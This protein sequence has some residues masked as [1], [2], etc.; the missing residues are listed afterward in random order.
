MRR[1]A[2]GATCF[3]GD[4]RTR[5]RAGTTRYVTG[6]VRDRVARA[7]WRLAPVAI[8]IAEPHALVAD[9][10]RN[11]ILARAAR[12]LFG[13][14]HPP[15]D[16]GSC[17]P[18]RCG[19]GRRCRCRCSLGLDDRR[20]W[21]RA[22]WCRCN[23]RLARRLGGQRLDLHRWMRRDAVGGG[24][25]TGR[26]GI[27]TRTTRSGLR[28]PARR[29]SSGAR[30]SLRRGI[31]RKRRHHACIVAGFRGRRRR[32]RRARAC[33][34]GDEGDQCHDDAKG[35][36]QHGDTEAAR[37]RGINGDR[38]R[39]WRRHPR[40]R[41]G[42]RAARDLERIAAGGECRSLGV[43]PP[44]VREM[45]RRASRRCSPRWSSRRRGPRSKPRTIAKTK[46]AKPKARRAVVTPP[47][48][49]IAKP[50]TAERP[51]LDRSRRVLPDDER[52][53]LGKS[54]RRAQASV[55]IG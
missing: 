27:D 12:Q 51:A 16:G 24:C 38:G 53:D 26:W 40:R 39:R 22:L 45:T 47:I 6:R 17:L 37:M 23:G 55:R 9:D 19:D 32:R 50:R 15:V 35:D 11:E 33:L 29:R 13:H 31:R 25:A 44:R 41:A 42:V 52:L 4:R 43:G 18:R 34:P 48:P 46:T 3:S 30:R 28:R 5:P 21:R 8:A 49:R 20:G 2:Q 36:E 1:S 54:R 10:A 7:L 14:Q